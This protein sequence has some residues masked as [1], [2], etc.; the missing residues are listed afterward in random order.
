MKRV[1]IGD[2]VNTQDDRFTLDYKMLV[3][4]LQRRL[5]NPREAPGPI[6]SASSDER[7]T[8]AIALHTQAITVILDF[9]KPLRAGGNLYSFRRNAELKRFKHAPYICGVRKFARL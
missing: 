1:E 9:V 7:H 5:G 6:I 2:P 4:V 8:I 3:A